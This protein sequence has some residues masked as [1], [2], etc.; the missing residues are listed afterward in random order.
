MPISPFIALTD[1]NW[2]DHLKRNA[3][4][5]QIVDAQGVALQSGTGQ[6][7][8]KVETHDEKFSMA[9]QGQ[10]KTTTAKCGCQFS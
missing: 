2:F 3:N 8:L 10:R 7:Y 9:N 6:P 4:A 5:D 1:K